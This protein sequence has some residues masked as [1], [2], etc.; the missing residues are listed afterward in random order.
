MNLNIDRKTGT[1]LP[2]SNCEQARRWC[3]TW[4]N[5]PE[6]WHALLT[7]KM[8]GITYGCVGCEICPTT[9]RAHLQGYL[10]FK[11]GT[12]LST[13][14]KVDEKIH[15]ERCMGD[16]ASN[17]TYCQK[18]GRFIEWGTK[19]EQGRRTDL[20][21][22]QTLI[23]NGGT[24]LDVAETNFGAFVRY[25]RGIREYQYLLN[26]QA[27]RVQRDV[28][29]YIYWGGPGT[30]KSR[31]VWQLHPDVFSVSEGN[32]GTWW[33][34]YE[35][36]LVVLLDDFRGTVP[37]HILL[38]WLDRYPVQVPI[39]GGYTWLR[40]TK[41]YITTNVNPDRLYINC[42]AASRAALMRRVTTIEHFGENA[43][44]ATGNTRLSQNFEENLDNDF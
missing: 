22:V 25:G 40:A 8:K 30:G 2:G 37:L 34:G 11:S 5:Y 28:E 16:Q 32:T 7:G 26:T 17:I 36:Q 6:F 15:W 12:R 29:V 9:Q 20:E 43:T 21:E 24:M 13:L 23:R 3:F 33:T 4:H 38:K 1:P 14:K 27:A 39:H 31:R 44:E 18:E 42:D 35:G 41:I 10:E 19:G